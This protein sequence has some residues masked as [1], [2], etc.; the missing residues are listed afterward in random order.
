MNNYNPPAE[1]TS[2]VNLAQSALQDRQEHAALY[3]TASQD[4]LRHLVE[5]DDSSSLPIV[6]VD[7]QSGDGLSTFAYAIATSCPNVRYIELRKDVTE[8]EVILEHIQSTPTDHALLLLDN[9]STFSL[10]DL[11][12]FYQA[13]RH[14]EIIPVFFGEFTSQTRKQLS[15]LTQATVCSVCM[16]DRQA[17]IQQDELVV[18]P[19]K[20]PFKN[21]IRYYRQ[22]PQSWSVYSVLVTLFCICSITGSFPPNVSALGYIS[23]LFDGLFQLCMWR[24]IS[25]H[26]QFAEI[27]KTI[28]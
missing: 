25:Q 26:A 14:A 19:L 5:I 22:T 28:F 18:V 27:Q 4:L 11:A 12:S 1:S 23:I 17:I 16:I 24:N 10:E 2:I 21:L 8:V 6:C 7:G 9:I 15:K 13:C 3:Y 20:I